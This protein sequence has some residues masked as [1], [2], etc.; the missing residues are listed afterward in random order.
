MITLCK[1]SFVTL[2]LLVSAN[3]SA[4]FT[5]LSVQ[6]YGQGGFNGPAVV[7][8]SS[9]E[10]N[11]YSWVQDDKPVILEGHI[12]NSLGGDHYL[13]Q[14]AKGSVMVEIDHE[15]WW[16]VNA[17]PQTRLRLYGSVD[18]DVAERVSVDVDRLEKLS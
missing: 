9:D 5:D 16:G 13:F 10:I 8:V 15:E 14:D 6:N 4:A 7:V 3:A 18:K 1:F 2:V 11:S 12:V 17:T